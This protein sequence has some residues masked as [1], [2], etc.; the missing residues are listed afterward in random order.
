[1]LSGESKLA[2]SSSM[3]TAAAANYRMRIYQHLGSSD[4]ATLDRWSLRVGLFYIV[5]AIGVVAVTLSTDNRP[6]AEQLA[7]TS[8]RPVSETAKDGPLELAGSRPVLQP[9]KR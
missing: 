7:K 4:R 6:K 9:V 8:T 2:E 1:M 3:V 5:V